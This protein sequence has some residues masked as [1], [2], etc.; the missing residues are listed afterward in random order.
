MG[1]NPILEQILTSLRWMSF[2]RSEIWSFNL[3]TDSLKLF[4]YSN[5]LPESFVSLPFSEILN[6][7]SLTGPSAHLPT[8]GTSSTVALF[9]F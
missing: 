9:F 5:N 7:Y 6:H 4:N 2:S 1:W 3:D 8:D